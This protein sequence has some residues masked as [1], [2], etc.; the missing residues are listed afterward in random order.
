M[1][2]SPALFAAVWAALGVAGLAGCGEQLAQ[3]ARDH[4]AVE[5]AEG[6]APVADERPRVQRATA[7]LPAAERGPVRQIGGR[8]MWADSRRYS[9]QENA[10][11]QFEQH[12][13]ELQA[14]DLDDFLAKAHRFVSRPPRG[15]LT[16]TRA[17]GD[18]LI[19][20]GQSGLFGVARADGAPR[21]VF[22]PDDG[23]AYWATQ[24]RENASAGRAAAARPA[25]DGG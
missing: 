6:P 7:P 24:V 1:K 22:K 16:L 2:C 13:A 11:Y 19:Y 18:T 8:P 4:R 9:A 17:N 20:D 10:A 14:R 5:L 25:R 21:I 15:A 12:G 23:E 3:P